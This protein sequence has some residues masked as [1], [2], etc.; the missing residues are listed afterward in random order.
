MSTPPTSSSGGTASAASVTKRSSV[1]TARLSVE[2]NARRPSLA[3]TPSKIESSQADDQLSDAKAR[4]AKLEEELEQKSRHVEQLKQSLSV[5]RESKPVVVEA[6][7][8]VADSAP[9]N[10]TQEEQE[11]A[12]DVDASA[13]EDVAMDEEA[14]LVDQIAIVK[15]EAEEH[16]RAVR[17][18]L[19]DYIAQLQSENEQLVDELRLENA[20]QASDI[21][22]LEAEIVQR[23]ARIA[24]FTADEQK[25]AEDVALAVAKTSTGAR[26]VEALEAQVAEFQ[27]MIEMMTLDKETLEMDK[28]IAEER[29]EELL[30]EMEKLKASVALASAAP[31]P[32]ALEEFG[33]SADLAEE[34]K[35]LRAA[36]KA[37]HDR[38]AEEKADLSKKLRQYQRENAELVNLRDEVEQ[39]VRNSAFALVQGLVLA[40]YTLRVSSRLNAV[41]SWKPKSRS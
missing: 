33:S 18:E 31:E 26:K 13:D 40:T 5:M 28:E 15:S 19:E 21:K 8:H 16:V 2:P 1:G 25:K 17:A 3:R 34:N 12:M 35:K 29:V 14:N 38:A 27:D 10:E 32:K 36:I 23:N 39:L 7:E 22:S 37:L 41:P 6:S 11:E 30:G 24:Q 4:I 9:A 20:T